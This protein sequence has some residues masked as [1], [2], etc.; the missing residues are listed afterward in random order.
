MA[1]YQEVIKQFN[2]MCDS[3]GTSCDGCPINEQRGIFQ[4]WRWITEEPVKAEEIITNWA[5]KNPPVTNAEKFKEVFGFDF[6][7]ANDT[8]SPSWPDLWLES[9]YKEPEKDE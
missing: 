4:C 5:K 2:R 7:E 8:T 3:Y 9:E 6:I 1:E